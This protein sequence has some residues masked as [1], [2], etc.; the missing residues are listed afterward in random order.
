MCEA[1]SQNG[2]CADSLETVRLEQKEGDAL[3]RSLVSFSVGGAFI[4]TGVIMFLS[5]SANGGDI[6][7][8]SGI[9]PWITPHELGL[10]GR[11]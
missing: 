3:T 9:T 11:F 6:P 7:E 10:S 2:M 5:S 1:M 4:A 8:H